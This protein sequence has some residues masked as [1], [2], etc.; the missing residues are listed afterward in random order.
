MARYCIDSNALN[1]LKLVTDNHNFDVLI[2]YKNKVFNSSKDLSDEL[3]V[4]GFD[5]AKYIKKVYEL[6]SLPDVKYSVSGNDVIIGYKLAQFLELKIDDSIVLVSQGFRGASAVG[7]YKIAGYLNFPAD[8]F[9]E[10]F[11]YMP[12]KT[13]QIFLSAF[14]IENISDTTFFVNYIALNT[15][16]QASVRENDYK[17]ILKVKSEIEQKIENKLITVVGWHNLNKDLIQGIE[18]DNK[19]GKIMIFVLYLIIAFGVLGTVMMMIA[20]RKREFGMMMAVG[21]KKNALSFIVTIEM[22]FMGMIAGLFGII[23]TAPIVW[24]GH[25]YPIKLRGEMAKSMDMYNMEPVLPLQNFDTYVLSQL[26]VVMVIVG[27]VLIYALLKINKLNVIDAL[28]S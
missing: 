4:M 3:F 21:L 19:N 15:I 2:K 13:T 12:I 23:I 10:R 22:F 9:N 25:K 26:A 6:T 1:K 7:K 17:K 5:T 14:E 24:I 20:E 18:M 27:I 8:A 11:I 28:K 16:Y